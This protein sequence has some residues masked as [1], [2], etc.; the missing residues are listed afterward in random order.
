[1]IENL[2]LIIFWSA[3]VVGVVRLFGYITEKW[4]TPPKCSR[5]PE[6]ILFQHGYDGRWDC[7]VC[8]EEM[9]KK[10]KYEKN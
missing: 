10:R 2:L 5:H 6:A 1:M 8:F 7:P 4:D 9:M 3:F